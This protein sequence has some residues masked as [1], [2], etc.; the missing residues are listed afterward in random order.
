MLRIEPWRIQVVRGRDLRSILWRPK[1]R[2]PGVVGGLGGVSGPRAESGDAPA[3][4]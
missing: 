4:R 2:G 3:A 1:A